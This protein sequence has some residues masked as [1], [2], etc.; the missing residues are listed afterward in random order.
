MQNNWITNCATVVTCTDSNL[1]RALALELVTRGLTVAGIGHDAG[2]LDQIRAQAA[3]LEGPGRFHPVVLDI[4]DDASVADEF[5]RIEDLLGPIALLINNAEPCPRNDILQETSQSFMAGIRSNLGGTVACT[6]AALRSMTQTGQGRIVNII[7]FAGECP[8]TASAARSV[9]GAAVRAFS[10]AL[11]ADLRDRFPRIVVS[12][13][14]PGT[15]ATPM[16][17]DGL[18]P[19]ELAAKWGATLAL[20]HDAALNGLV[21][22]RDHEV[23]PSPSVGQKIKHRIIM[24]RAR[25]P[26]RLDATG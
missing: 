20:W 18:T 5:A 13:W 2:T 19:P 3:A 8:V 11:V 9:S 14:S 17:G 6:H 10:R 4:A 24:R 15:L 12:D 7:S 22:E 1:G 16:N 25:R 23:V 21:F 26:L